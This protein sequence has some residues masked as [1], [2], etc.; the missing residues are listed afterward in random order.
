MNILGFLNKDNDGFF[1]PQE[2][3]ITAETVIAAFEAFGQRYA[4]YYAQTKQPGIV[5]VDNAPVHTSKAFLKKLDDW[6]SYGLMVHFLPTYSPELNLIE[7]LWRKMKYEWL[8][9]NAYQS[10]SSLKDEVI[11]I[12]EQV[13]V[14]YTITFA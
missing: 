1:Y 11:S 8:S 6:Y 12:L 2:G 5:I 10:Y 4:E 13:G 7:I 14:K 3:K 9:F